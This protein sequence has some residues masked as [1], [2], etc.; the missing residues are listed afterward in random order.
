MP[1]LHSFLETNSHYL[2]ITVGL[3]KVYSL[4]KDTT[5]KLPLYVVDIPTTNNYYS[6][7]ATPANATC[8]TLRYSMREIKPE[9]QI[10]TPWLSQIERPFDTRCGVPGGLERL[11]FGTIRAR[12]KGEGRGG[13]VPGSI[14]VS[15]VVTQPGHFYHSPARAIELIMYGFLKKNALG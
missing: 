9:T 2:V 4:R 6:T 12:R 10:W 5:Q 3:G 7:S 15:K 1:N 8:M 14:G 13:L 11:W